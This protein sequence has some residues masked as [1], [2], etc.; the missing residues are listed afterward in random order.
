M[1]FSLLVQRISRVSACEIRCCA[2]TALAMHLAAELAR[3]Q[4]GGGSG[5]SI[6]PQ[7]ADSTVAQPVSQLIEIAEEP[8]TIDPTALLPEILA[9]RATVQFH[10]QPLRDVVKWLQEERSLNVLVNYPG[11]GGRRNSRR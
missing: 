10:A 9:A 5:T 1:K 6:E 8:K 11:A 7:S 2:V 4:F 3:A